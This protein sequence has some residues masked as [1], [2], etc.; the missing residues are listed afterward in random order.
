M[1]KRQVPHNIVVPHT[2]LID[3][4]FALNTDGKRFHHELKNISGQ[5]LT[6]LKQPNGFCWV[7]YDQRGHK[8]ALSLFEEY[9]RGHNVKAFKSAATIEYLAQ[10]IKTPETA[11][12]SVIDTL[13]KL[14]DENLADEFGR[15]FQ[16]SHKLEPPFYYVKVTGSLFH[17]QGGICVDETARALR[18]DGT[19][20]PNLFAGGG[21]MRAVSGPAEWG[22]LPGMGLC[23]AIAFG[24]RAGLEAARLVQKK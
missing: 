17:T 20:I 12:R 23:T 19:I 21:A 22:Y 24:W 8:K 9:R 4:G 16:P 7:I 11:L 6:V 5:A 18:T 10:N 1:Y 14:A 2:V 15:E 13:N 3:G